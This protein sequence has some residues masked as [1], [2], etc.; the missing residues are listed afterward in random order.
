MAIQEIGVGTSGFDILFWLNV[1][2]NKC[3]GPPIKERGPEPFAIQLKK[4]NNALN[5]NENNNNV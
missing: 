2:A 4:S 3:H 5:R 1:V